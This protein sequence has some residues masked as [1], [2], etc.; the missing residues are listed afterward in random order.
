MAKIAGELAGKPLRGNRHKGGRDL[1][2]ILRHFNIPG[3]TGRVGF[4]WCTA[5]VYHCC[6][7]AGFAIPA[8]PPKPVKWSLAAVPAWIQWA[9][10]PGNRFYYSARNKR[11]RPRKGDLVIFDNILGGGPHDHMGV[12]LSSR[13]GR[14]ITAEGNVNNMSGIFERD[15]GRH[16]RGFIR[17]SETRNGRPPVVIGNAGKKDDLT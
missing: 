15:A 3:K 10:L 5:F 17:I 9:K 2:P 4:D 1:E 7:E 11:F 13:R 12:I 14:L 16:I 6:L 8:R